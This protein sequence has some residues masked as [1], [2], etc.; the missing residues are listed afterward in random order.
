MAHGEPAVLPPPASDPDSAPPAVPQPD[1]VP[2]QKHPALDSTCT[3]RTRQI[4]GAE[5]PTDS[6]LNAAAAAAELAEDEARAR[7]QAREEEVEDAYDYQGII[8]AHQASQCQAWDDWAMFDEMNTKKP[9]RRRVLRMTVA[10]PGQQGTPARVDVPF[11]TNGTGQLQLNFEVV[12]NAV[13]EDEGTPTTVPFE[14]GHDD[15]KG[16]A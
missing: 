13:S 3:T 10:T 16:S 11:E 1:S 7:E 14:T 8:Q 5:S 6:E 2:P 12:H 15:A 9:K 4:R